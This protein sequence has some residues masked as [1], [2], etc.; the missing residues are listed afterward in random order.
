MFGWGTCKFQGIEA[1]LLTDGTTKCEMSR[2]FEIHFMG[3]TKACEKDLQITLEG[4]M[5][6]PAHMSL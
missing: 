1:K 6:N 5:N 3:I 4:F 2:G